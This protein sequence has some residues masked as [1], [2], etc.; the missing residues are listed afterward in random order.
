MNHKRRAFLNLVD[1]L[2]WFVT[3]IIIFGTLILINVKTSGVI[4]LAH[5]ESRIQRQADMLGVTSSLLIGTPSL[6]DQIAISMLAPPV[7]MNERINSRAI[8]GDQS[9]LALIVRNRDQTHEYTS[10]TNPPQACEEQ[11]PL[12]PTPLPFLTRDKTR[13]IWK[14]LILEKP[15]VCQQKKR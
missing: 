3:L 4:H 9:S 15:T 6:I 12:S 2:V 1:I 8:T 11:T 10:F 7:I 14:T 13:M 5:P